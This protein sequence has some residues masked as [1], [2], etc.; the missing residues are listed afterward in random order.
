LITST[1]DDEVKN[2][3][4]AGGRVILLPSDK[5]TLAPGFEIVPR[6]GSFLDGNWISSY[7]WIRK[8]QEP[9]KA[10]GFETL[11]GFE[12]QSV[13]PTTVVQGLK[14]E[15]S[16]DVLAG[17][18]YGWIH[19]NVGALVQARSG[20][21]KLLICTFSLGTTYGS[22]PYSTYLLDALVQYLVSGPTP[23]LDIPL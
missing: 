23:T 20:Q 21:G 8:N 15:Q 9:F 7:L 11:P 12:V 10:I 16:S 17:L 1:F 13:A 6:A 5:Q 19:S 2:L 14:P 22:D 18:F 4:R 3:L